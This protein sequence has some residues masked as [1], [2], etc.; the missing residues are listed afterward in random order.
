LRI[1]VKVRRNHWHSIEVIGA[2][3]VGALR[4]TDAF[5]EIDAGKRSKSEVAYH[6][7]VSQL[8]VE[9]KRVATVQVLAGCADQWGEERAI[10]GEGSERVADFT[11]NSGP[12]IDCGDVMIRHDIVICGWRSTRA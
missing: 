3:R 4:Y 9:R 8:I 12:G 2:R 5:I 10:C 6:P 1:V 7:A 11:I